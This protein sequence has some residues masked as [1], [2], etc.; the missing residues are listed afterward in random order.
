MWYVE[1]YELIHSDYN[2]KTFENVAK[3]LF[4]NTEYDECHEL[5]F[6]T[7]IDTY[8]LDGYKIYSVEFNCKKAMKVIKRSRGNV[9]G[10]SKIRLQKMI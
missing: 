10:V 6:L 7:C 4:R 8:Y 2:F 5:N 3:V 9:L 1:D